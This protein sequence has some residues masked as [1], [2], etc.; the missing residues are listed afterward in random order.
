MMQE[1]TPTDGFIPQ[2]CHLCEPE[3]HGHPDKVRRLLLL[4]RIPEGIVTVRANGPLPPGHDSRGHWEGDTLVVESSH[5]NDQTA[6]QGSSHDLKVVPP[7]VGR[8]GLVCEEVGA[9]ERER[10]GGAAGYLI[11]PGAVKRRERF[12]RVRAA[13]LV[14][15]L[16]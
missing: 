2:G 10:V 5:F 6:W 4:D 12:D 9:G 13:Q 16:P 11:D 14:G 8:L 7:R 15:L 3:A 1:F